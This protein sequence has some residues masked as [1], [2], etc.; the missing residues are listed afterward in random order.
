MVN[1]LIRVELLYHDNFNVRFYIDNYDTTWLWIF[2]YI[3]ISMSFG[4][5]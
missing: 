5:H 1:L 4:V 2:S 3:F